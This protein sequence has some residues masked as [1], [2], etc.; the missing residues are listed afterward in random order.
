MFQFAFL[1]E[2]QLYNNWNSRK[3]SIFL[4]KLWRQMT[5]KDVNYHHKQKLSIW[6]DLVFL[7]TNRH[8]QSSRIL[9]SCL[10]IFFLPFLCIIYKN[11]CKSIFHTHY[12]LRHEKMDRVFY[13]Y[14]FFFFIP[15]AKEFIYMRTILLHLINLVNPRIINVASMW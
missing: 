2:K 10:I 13:C 14:S 12:Y 3:S 9:E 6:T 8:K 11:I 5:L 1:V 4:S 15:H 7:E